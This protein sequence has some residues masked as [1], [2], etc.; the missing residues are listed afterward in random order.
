MGVRTPSQS[1]NVIL[2]SL[3]YPPPPGRLSST[4]K[5]SRLPASPEASAAARANWPP[6][7]TDPIDRFVA[8]PVPLETTSGNGE[9]RERHRQRQRQQN[10]DRMDPA[11]ELRRQ[12]QYVKDLQIGFGKHLGVHATPAVLVSGR[13]ILGFVPAWAMIDIINEEL[14][15]SA[16]VSGKVTEVT[17]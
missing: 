9:Q 12:D 10:G 4:E 1:R 16:R 6:M 5:S 8:A 13:L 7:I 17:P 15:G 11:L 3:R 14:R 2:T